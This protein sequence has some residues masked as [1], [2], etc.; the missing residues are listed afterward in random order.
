MSI[1][2]S[3]LHW[4]ARKLAELSDAL[5]EKKGEEEGSSTSGI[6]LPYAHIQKRL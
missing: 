4:R 6:C 3:V 2:C 5:E 1:L